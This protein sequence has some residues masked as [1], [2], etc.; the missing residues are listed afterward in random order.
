MRLVARI[1]KAL[2]SMNL[3]IVLC[4]LLA[5]VVVWGYLAINWRTALFIPLNDMGLLAWMKTY[6]RYNLNHTGW[7]FVL[8][9]LLVLLALNTVSC[10]LERV[11]QLVVGR[12]S[13]SFFRLAVKL[14]PHVMHVAVLVMLLG[15]LTSYLYTEVVV[16]AVLLPGRSYTL[17]G[18]SGVITFTEFRHQL[19]QGERLAVFQGEVIQP[20]AALLLSDKKGQHE[21]MLGFNRPVRLGGYS[22]HLDNFAPKKPGGMRLNQRID[23]HIRKDPGLVLYMTGIGLFCLGLGL[24]MLD[25]RIYRKPRQ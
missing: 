9:L 3:T 24:Y 21:A 2:G 5:A 12:S 14:G 1:W 22:I 25:G 23:L 18:K 19:Y 20:Q 8:L 15:Y 6:G 4:L 7:F 17:P 13:F 16:S 10:T 11:W